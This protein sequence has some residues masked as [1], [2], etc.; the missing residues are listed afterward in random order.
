MRISKTFNSKILFTLAIAFFALNYQISAQNMSLDNSFN[1]GVTDSSTNNYV[2]AVQPDGKILTGGNYNFANG[3]SELGG[4]N[5]P[6][7]FFSPP[8]A[9]ATTKFTK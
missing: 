8:T 2:S 5:Q 4:G 6:I 9:T 1:A 3:M 7:L